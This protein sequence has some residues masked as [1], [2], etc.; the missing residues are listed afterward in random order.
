MVT[1]LMSSNV[2]ALELRSMYT[3]LQTAILRKG[4]HEEGGML[5]VHNGNHDENILER[6]KPIGLFG[7]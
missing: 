4:N 2:W 7:I 5:Q 6:N 1:L 3:A